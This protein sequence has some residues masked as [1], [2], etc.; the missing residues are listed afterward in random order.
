[1]SPEETRKKYPD[2]Q[3]VFDQI[4]NDKEHLPFYIA[5]CYKKRYSASNFIRLYPEE[6]YIITQVREKDHKPLLVSIIK[7]LKSSTNKQ[8]FEMIN[9]MHETARNEIE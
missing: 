2:K 6:Y 1:M 4:D 7:E 3:Y 5:E 8:I 9:H